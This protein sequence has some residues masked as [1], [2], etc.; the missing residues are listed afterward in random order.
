[1]PEQEA[2]AV[3]CTH[4]C[5]NACGRMYDGIWISAIDGST[6]FYCVP[7]WGAFLVQLQTAMLNPDDVQVQEVIAGTDLSGVVVATTHDP[8]FITGIPVSVMQ[9]DEFVFD[10]SD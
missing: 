5:Q 7:C 8:G 9:D 1:M 10:G 2:S 3:V 4:A 6:L